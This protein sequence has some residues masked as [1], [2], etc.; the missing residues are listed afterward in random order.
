MNPLSGL[1]GA[2]VSARNQ[3]YERGGLKVRRL[4][5]PVVSIGNI[6]VGGSGK[7]P[8]LIMLGEMLRERGISFDVLS[9]GYGRASKGV[10]IVDPGGTPRDFGDEPLLIARKLRAPV[11]VGEDR[12]AAGRLAEESFDSQLHLLDDGF[13]HRRLARDLDVVLLTPTDSEDS[14][15]PAGRLREPLSS[16]ARAHV[17]V[18]TDATTSEGLPLKSQ[19]VWR[20]Q[21]RIVPPEITAP[22]VAFCGIARPQDFFVRLQAAGIVL[23]ATRAFRDHHSYGDAD[24]QELLRLRRQSSAAAFVTTEK[25]AINLGQHLARLEPIHVAALQLSLED[26]RVAVDLLLSAIRIRPRQPA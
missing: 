24:V 2:V 3:L 20:V 17:V 12:Y 13:Q 19:P 11:V 14:L 18:L 26:A 5:R 4:Q 23:A 16:L 6:A 21:R 9:R 1:Y 22:C 7:T 25:D 10:R 15:L 8:F